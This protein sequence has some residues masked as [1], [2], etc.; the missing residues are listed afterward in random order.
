MFHSSMDKLAIQ[1][2]AN[3]F[4]LESVL[5]ILIM[6]PSV[7]CWLFLHGW[8]EGQIL[9]LYFMYFSTLFRNIRLFFGE[10]RR[11]V[12]AFFTCTQ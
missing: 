10:K 4:S 12:S 6:V 11:D 8:E 2:S 7:I 5:E 1:E 3:G 9:V